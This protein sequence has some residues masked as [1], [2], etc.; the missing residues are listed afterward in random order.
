MYDGVQVLVD[1][2]TRLLRK[3]PDI[4][5]ASM[6]RNANANATRI[7]DCNPKGKATPL[8]HGDKISKM[9]K[10]VSYKLSWYCS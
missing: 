7:I 8:E 4:F 6:R 10:K 2:I 1:A 3:K 9:I 5:R